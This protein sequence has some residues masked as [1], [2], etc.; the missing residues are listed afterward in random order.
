M[1][2]KFPDL[3]TSN[4]TIQYDTDF[5][6]GETPLNSKP[7]HNTASIGLNFRAGG[8]FGGYIV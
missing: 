8:Q 5:D 7:F 3:I 2:K 1:N 6:A 4:N